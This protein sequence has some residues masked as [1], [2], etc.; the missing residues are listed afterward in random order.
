MRCA[1][2]VLQAG[3]AYRRGHEVLLAAQESREE[4]VVAAGNV[5]PGQRTLEGPLLAAV[6]KSDCRVGRVT[7]I[8]EPKTSGNVAHTV[9]VPVVW[10]AHRQPRQGSRW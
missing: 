7:S 9:A 6:K 10:V 4:A 2:T 3:R 1:P 8:C 5:S